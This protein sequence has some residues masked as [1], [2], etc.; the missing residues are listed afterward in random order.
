MQDALTETDAGC[1]LNNNWRVQDTVSSGVQRSFKLF[2]ELN[3]TAYRNIEQQVSLAEVP[4]V[5]AKDEESLDASHLLFVM[6]INLTKIA[7]S[8]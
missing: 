8:Y 6:S 7:K 2:R 3:S 5:R 1:K 4:S